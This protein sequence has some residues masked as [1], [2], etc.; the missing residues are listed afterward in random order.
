M[1]IKHQKGEKSKWIYIIHA[2]NYT[3]TGRIVFM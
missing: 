1:D 3:E 2:K